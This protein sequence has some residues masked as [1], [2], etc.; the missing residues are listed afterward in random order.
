[1]GAATISVQEGGVGIMILGVGVVVG[2]TGEVAGGV[3]Q[4]VRVKSKRRNV[5]SFFI[6]FPN[7]LHNLSGVRRK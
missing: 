1:V 4:E 5:M 6:R 2:P 3:V 7:S